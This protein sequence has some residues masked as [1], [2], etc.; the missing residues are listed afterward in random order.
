MIAAR[1]MVVQWPGRGPIRPSGQGS[2][3]GWRRAA[4]PDPPRR[5]DSSG[6]PRTAVP[7][8]DQA[9]AEWPAS[10]CAGRYADRPARDAR[11]HA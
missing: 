4:L 9:S 2:G 6:H 8:P 11:A 1:R 7:D 3:P 10:G 5:T